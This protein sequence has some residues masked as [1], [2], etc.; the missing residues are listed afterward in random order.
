[1]LRKEL[2]KDLLKSV[3]IPALGLSLVLGVSL[4]AFAFRLISSPD[5][6][7]AI[8][9]GKIL[10]MAGEVLEGGTVLIRKGKI[11]DVGLEV[12]VPPEAK[13]IEAE[14]KYIMPGIVDAMCYFGIRPEDRND[15]TNPVTP[16]NRIIH[17]FYPF[18]N[19]LREEG[20][21]ERS[22]ELLSGGVTT[23]YI[24]PGNRQV[25]GGQGAV[26]KTF[27]ER[28]E[29][30]IVRECASIDI[31]LGDPP[32]TAF[33]SKK[34]SPLTRMSV[35]SLIRK[36]LISAE[37]YLKKRARE[38]EKKGEE[39]SPPPPRD[40]AME[41]MGM[42]LRKEIPARVEADLPDDIR[43]AIRI[44]E[45]FNFN[46]IIDSG[47]GA[48]RLRELLAEKKIPV[49]LGPV[50]HPFSSGQSVEETP[51]LATLREE[52]Q[53]ALLQEAG[54]KIA[55]ASFA[56]GR[57]YMGSS[58]QGRWVLLEAAL[59]SA[60][61]LKEEEALKAVTINAAEILGVSDRVGSLERGKDADLIILDG[62]P[63]QIRTRVE[64]VFGGGR[65]I[66]Q[67]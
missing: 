25:I 33:G 37:E 17:A 4:C 61:G 54:V 10:T 7:F 43:T 5:S 20:G 21:E 22:S 63:L 11:E 45:E 15:L 52:R 67:R 9:G 35:A 23:I 53:A 2:V 41:A 39:K 62:H 44:A 58:S 51:E 3:S 40:L 55:L 28:L 57:G 47:A 19:F 42:L 65:L 14:G 6:I 36:T 64:K 34:Q 50:S 13:I 1:M 60:F 49:V 24:A 16:Q 38:E 18:R 59:A 30:M 48:Y 8:K 46:L 27:G 56:Y 66:Y 32:K 29:E 26:V 31:T 12:K